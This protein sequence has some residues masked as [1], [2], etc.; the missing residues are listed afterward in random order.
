MKPVNNP[1]Q[2]GAVLLV[3]LVMLVIITLIGVSTASVIRDNGAVLINF[4]ARAAVRNAAISALQQVV[5]RGT[6]VSTGVVFSSP[7]SGAR[8]VCIDADGDGSAVAGRDIEVTIGALRCVSATLIRNDD[9]NVLTSPVDA[10]CYQPQ[11]VFSLCAEAIW[12]VE[13]TAFDPVTGAKTTVRQGLSTRAPANT[14][15]LACNS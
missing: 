10:S 14:V 15:N 12:D 9:L 4:E 6:I 8:T 3:A 13:A 5:A 11:Q 1:R 2:Q 7:C